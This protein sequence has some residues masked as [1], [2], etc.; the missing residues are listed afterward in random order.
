MQWIFQFAVYNQV[1][2][3]RKRLLGGKS[4]TKKKK[5]IIAVVAM[6]AVAGGV[7]LK[8]KQAQPT[9]PQGMPV[10]TSTIQKQDIQ[11]VLKQ[12]AVLE[13]TKSAEVVSRLHYEIEQI[14][15]KEGDRV[16]QGQLLAVLDSTEIQQ[17][18]AQTKGDLELLGYQ[19]Q[20]ILDERQKQ[21][22]NAVLVR[23]QAKREYERQQQLFDGNVG[24][25]AELDT[26]KDALDKAEQEVADIPTKNGT[27]VLTNAEKQTK[28]NAKQKADIQAT[29]LNDCKIYS[30]ISGAVTR[31]NT[32]V[33]RFADEMENNTPIFVIE[34]ID[35]LQMKVMIS[36]N[37]IDK[38]K[39]GQEVDITAEILGK[40]VVKGV[41]DRISPTGEEKNGTTTERVIPVYIKVQEQNEKLIAGIT[42][43]ATI[44][45]AFVQQAFVVPLEAIGE[46]EDGTT[47]VYTVTEEG[48]VHIVPVTVGLET[49][50]QAEVKSD[51]LAEGQTII[52]NPSLALAEGTAVIA[53]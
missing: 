10:M 46:L 47:A 12:K 53:Q 42:A 3:K 36:E 6:V 24:T 38:V 29:T 14:A 2:E 4:M 34:D 15:V 32:T 19:Q 35:H 45:I 49:D 44:K 31:V 22:N 25:Q 26:A 16:K 18:M 37:D 28:I 11:E 21:Y 20:D 9:E 23:D 40:D 1:Y 8:I 50:L 17:Q 30:P 33:G 39:I 7:G 52:L 48:T 27:A 13:G 5:I 43:Q 41:V 51:E